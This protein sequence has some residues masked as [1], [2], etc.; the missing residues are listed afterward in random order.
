LTYLYERIF[1]KKKKYSVQGGDT[2]TKGVTEDCGKEK[3]PK[4]KFQLDYL[5]K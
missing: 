3:L 1:H 5:Q 4:I 2:S